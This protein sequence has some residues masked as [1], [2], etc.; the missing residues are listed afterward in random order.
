V[1]VVLLVCQTFARKSTRGV[2]RWANGRLTGTLLPPPYPPP[3]P[4]LCPPS[5][6]LLLLCPRSPGAA[7]VPVNR[8]EEAAAKVAAAATTDAAATALAALCEAVRAQARPRDRSHFFHRYPKCV[9]GREVVD[10]VAALQA[11]PRPAAVAHAQRLFNTGLLFHVKHETGF[12]DGGALFR[13]QADADYDTKPEDLI[14]ASLRALPAVGVLPPA[15]PKARSGAGSGSRAST[16]ASA[17]ASSGSFVDGSGASSASST[18]AASRA[19]DSSSEEGGSGFGSA[20]HEDAVDGGA[21]AGKAAGA[22]LPAGVHSPP[23]LPPASAPPGAVQ[24]EAS[25]PHR[26]T[27]SVGDGVAVLL[28]GGS[29]VGPGIVRCPAGYVLMGVRKARC[30]CGT[31]VL[32][33]GRVHGRPSGDGVALSERV[34]ESITRV[35]DAALSADGTHVDYD[36]L[37]TSPEFAAFTHAT[38]ELQVCECVCVCARERERRFARRAAYPPR[39]VCRGRLCLCSE[40]SNPHLRCGADCGGVLSCA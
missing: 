1:R 19:D 26:R 6:L 7:G 35:Y 2:G 18:T 34:R 13:F 4:L 8:A 5:R 3:H 23:P 22:G 38:E 20:G 25:G 24:R 39:S 12:V 14:A 29:A 17:S 30:V 11:C 21:S 28:A 40:S 16:S 32:N 31:L 10:A 27:S 33:L 37:L 36:G 9:E 15:S